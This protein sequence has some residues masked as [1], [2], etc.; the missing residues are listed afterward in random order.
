MAD[1]TSSARLAVTDLTRHRAAASDNAPLRLPDG[2]DLH[3]G[4]TPFLAW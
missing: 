3:F 1:V 4:P 2:K